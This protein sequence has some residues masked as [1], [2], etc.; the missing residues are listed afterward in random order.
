M[1]VKVNYLLES[2]ED[3]VRTAAGA[4]SYVETISAIALKL[5]E[6]FGRGGK[7]LACGNGGSAA[8]A[9]HLT[10]EWV[11]RFIRDRRSYPALALTA[12]SS[13][14][15]CLGNDY[16]YDSVF[17]RQVEGLGSAGD[18]LIGFSSSGNSENVIKAIQAARNMGITTVS[19]LG[20]DGGR[21]RGAADHE[22]IVHSQVTARIQEAHG[23]IVHLLCEETERLLGHI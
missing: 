11:G 1:T 17:S 10:G 7:L 23:L 12:D 8:D 20:R 4:S 13:L 21:M 3:A 9:A 22:I 14:L 18:M 19:L 15:T 6:T 16:G 5:S 2:I